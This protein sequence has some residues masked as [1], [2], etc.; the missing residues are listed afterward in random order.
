[1]TDDQRLIMVMYIQFAIFVGPAIVAW[2]VT[3]RRDYQHAKL[4]VERDLEATRRRQTESETRRT[5]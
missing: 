1:M 2:I 3:S 5:A 4:Q